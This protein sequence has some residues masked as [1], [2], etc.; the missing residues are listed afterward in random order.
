LLLSSALTPKLG[1]ALDCLQKGGTAW[2]LA[3][4]MALSSWKT[5]GDLR[6]STRQLLSS[7]PV[8]GALGALPPQVPLCSLL[9]LAFKGG[10]GHLWWLRQ[11]LVMASLAVDNF[12]PSFGLPSSPLAAD[13]RAPSRKRKDPELAVAVLEA[14]P[15]A[16]FKATDSVGH[17]HGLM[18]RWAQ[19]AVRL[20][21]QQYFLA[22]RAF[23]GC[24]MVL[25]VAVDASRVASQNILLGMVLGWV[26]GVCRG[27]WL[28]PQVR[29]SGFFE[30]PNRS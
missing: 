7:P 16:G 25:S 3:L 21:L 2:S 28:P 27:A 22:M 20:S 23:F 8:R 19:R 4:T 18:G 14:N 26:D 1:A 17:K 6:G 29:N 12:L 9:L 24:C 5:S 11:L 15:G 10:K 13:L 30:P